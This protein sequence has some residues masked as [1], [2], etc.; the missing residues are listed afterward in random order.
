MSSSARWQCEDCDRFNEPIAWYCARCRRP[1]GDRGLRWVEPKVP[2]RLVSSRP[3]LRELCER[4]Q[5]DPGPICH[6]PEIADLRTQEILDR[7]DIW[8]RLTEQLTP[9]E[10]FELQEQRA[11]GRGFRD[12]SHA[13]WRKEKA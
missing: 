6:C 7:W 13:A 12:M 10:L 8:E 1:R 9:G 11:H 2:P 4:P 5:P 3:V